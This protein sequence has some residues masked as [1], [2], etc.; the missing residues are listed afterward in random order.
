[1]STRSLIGYDDG[2]IH[3]IYCHYDGVPEH[4]GRLLVKHHNSLDA[5]TYIME[6]SQIRNFDNDGTVVRFHDCDGSTCHEV[7]SDVKDALNSCYDYVYL[8]DWKDNSWSCF[9]LEYPSKTLKRVIIPSDD[10]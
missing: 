8:Y 7:Y 3:G 9:T 2:V 10:E 6:G 5:C 1:M 4:V